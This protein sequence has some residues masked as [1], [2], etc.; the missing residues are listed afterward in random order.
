MLVTAGDFYCLPGGRVEAGENLIQAL[1]RE[2][3][4]EL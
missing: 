3:E 2:I 1:T 4:E